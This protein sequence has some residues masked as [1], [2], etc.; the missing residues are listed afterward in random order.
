MMTDP[1]SDM[2]THIRNAVRIE[3]HYVLAM[4][5]LAVAHLELGQLRRAAYW[6]NRATG[7]DGSQPRMRRLE[8]RLR[9]LRLKRW[10]RGVL[11]R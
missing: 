2:L 4:H 3:P 6:L 11:G 7:L 1:I 8:A 5:N 9:W 10:A